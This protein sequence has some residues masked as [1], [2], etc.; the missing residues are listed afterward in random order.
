VRAWLDELDPA[1]V[2]IELYADA[3]PGGEPVRVAM[4]RGEQLIG[5]VNA[6]KFTASVRA[7]RPAQ[8]FTP[9]IVPFHQSASV[10]LEANQILWYK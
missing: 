7:D 6:Y 5:S 1:A 2:R 4:G 8:D 3:L 10:P 9:R